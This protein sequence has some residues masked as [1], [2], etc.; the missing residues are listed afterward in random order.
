MIDEGSK[1]YQ[2]SVEPAFVV[3]AVAVPL[4]WAP[5]YPDRQ[6]ASIAPVMAAVVAATAFAYV[7]SIAS[8]PV[9]AKAPAAFYP[10]R[11]AKSTQSDPTHHRFSGGA[12]EAIAQFPVPP[13]APAAFYPDRPARS[14]ASNPAS[15][16]YA[17]VPAL[18]QYPPPALSW[19]PIF[20]DRQTRTTEAPQAAKPY[21]AETLGLPQFIIPPAITAAAFYPDRGWREPSH[22]NAQFLAWYAST[23]AAAGVP[24]PDGWMPQYPILP[25]PWTPRSGP[26]AYVPA[27]AQFPVPLLAPAAFYPDRQARS[28]EAPSA[29]KPYLALQLGLEQFI[30]PPL[31][32]WLPA[33]PDRQARTTEDGQAAK[34]SFF[35]GIGLEQ[36]SVPTLAWQGDY[37]IQPA[38]P[39]QRATADYPGFAYIPAVAQ[40]QV[41]A[42]AWLPV[43]PDRA[44]RI[45]VPLNAGWFAWQP[46]T[47]GTPTVP[48]SDS[49]APQFPPSAPPSFR[50]RESAFAYIPALA[51]FVAPNAWA[52]Y[53]TAAAAVPPNA[54]LRP[55]FVGSFVVQA[56]VPR[57]DSWAPSY[58]DRPR[59]VLLQQPGSIVNPGQPIIQGFESWSAVYPQRP[60]GDAPSRQRH[61][62]IEPPAIL[63]TPGLV[64]LPHFPDRQAASTRPLHIYQATFPWGK[65]VQIWAY[66]DVVRMLS[67]GWTVAGPFGEVFTVTGPSGEVFTITGAQGEQMVDAGPTAEGWKVTGPTGEEFKS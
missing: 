9:P 40:F 16:Y 39:S 51:Q 10:D 61:T 64:W 26:F 49:W 14:T 37:P 41:P 28:T 52:I 62:L 36:L 21:F 11:A 60:V 6:A 19:S 15:P 33:W 5:R 29:A 1:Q 12:I 20:P 13:L 42:L 43:Y 2:E 18:A 47:P 48:P 7:P 45:V 63:W 22:T 58:P 25:Q 59:I 8:F 50:A 34:P 31:L 24:S 32:S 46:L 44:G 56:P 17:F 38:A 65:I 3:P 35:Y 4:S 54:A 27:V 67:E 57:S 23:P 55:G 53:P 66:G 30:V